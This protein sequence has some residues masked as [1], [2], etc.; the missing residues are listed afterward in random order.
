VTVVYTA[1][2]GGYDT[3][4]PHPEHDGVD[5]WVCYTDD[6]QLVGTPGWSVF[7]H[8]PRFKHPRMDAKWWKCHPP[9][10]RAI[11]RSIWID[12]SMD[13]HDPEFFT[14]VLDRLN[15]DDTDQIRHAM[16]MFQHP[17]RTS[18]IDEARVSEQMTKYAG[19]PVVQQAHHYC[20]EWGWHDRELW[21]STTIGRYHNN[22]VLAFG[23]AWF[24]ECEGWTYQDQISLPPLLARYGIVPAALPHNLWRNPWFGLRGHASDL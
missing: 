9:S 19:L 18:I 3:L 12:G 7:V 16:V 21:A 4:K 22:R 11:D 17:V 8:P 20:N 15:G 10:I 2:Y 24:S 14:A 23:G 5:S 1:I 13:I 6:P